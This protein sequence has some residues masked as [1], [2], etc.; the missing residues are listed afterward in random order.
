MK[1]I[2]PGSTG[3]EVVNLS[4]ALGFPKDKYTFDEELRIAVVQYQ[5]RNNLVPDGIV[6]MDTWFM[7]VLEDREK[8]HRAPGVT[9]Y[10]YRVFAN[11]LD[12]DI[13]SLKAVKEVETGGR[14][15]FNKDGSVSIL[16]EAAVFYK[17]LKEVAIDPETLIQS[18]PGIIA[19][20]WDR[21]LYK[22]G[23]LEWSR[24]REAIEINEVAALKSA[25]WGIFQTMGFNYEKAGC[26]NIFDFVAK[27]QRSEFWQFILGL[28]FMKN[29][30]T[31]VYLRRHDWAGFASRYNG[32]GYKANAYDTKLRNAFNKYNKK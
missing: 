1:T 15:G 14:G 16:F 23:V 10:D 6:G 13:P 11:V 26:E 2:Q 20:K 7:I 27:M 19:R 24:L 8:N 31:L 12:I 25:S 18:H 28:Q 32:P 3:Q 22:G 29:S 17:Q 30:G 5:K 21:S 9:D 4:R